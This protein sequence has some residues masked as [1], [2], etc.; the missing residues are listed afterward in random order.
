MVAA[1]TNEKKQM[2]CLK[3]A[4]RKVS[5]HWMGFNL[6][7]RGLIAL[8]IALLCRTM[9]FAVPV[10]D[11]HSKPVIH[12]TVDAIDTAHKILSVRETIPLHGESEITL[13]YPRWEL[14]SH[15]PTVSMANLAGL[16]ITIG[17]HRVDWERDPLDAH[18][19]H[20]KLPHGAQSLD[21]QFQYLSPLN[22][23]TVITRNIVQVQWQHL[24]LYPKGLSVEKLPVEARL[25]LPPSFHAASSLQVD[26]IN[27]S[28][29]S[30]RETS[31]AALVDSPV[32]AGRY[33]QHWS[34]AQDDSVSL[35]LVADAPED[36]AVA[37][38]QIEALSAM[39]SAVE[40][41][42]VSKH[43]RRYKFLASASDVLPNDGGIE[44]LESGEIA[45]PADYFLKPQSY[46]QMATLFAHEFIH[47]WNGLY[48]RPEGMR[49]QDFN[50]PMR[51]SMLWVYE[52]LTEF[53]AM[54]IAKD[55]GQITQNQYLDML[56]LDA[57]MAV[58]RPGRAWKSLAD[59]DNDPVYLAGHHV[60]W[61]DW[62]RRED[63]Y[64]E[65]VLLWLNIDEQIRQCSSGN[66][67]I[68]DFVSSFFTGN[69]EQAAVSMY[70]FPDLIAAL[71]RVASFDWKQFF[72]IRLHAHDDRHVLDGLELA[73][74]RLV[75]NDS[76]SPLYLAQEA[77][78]E[79]IDLS[80]SIGAV[81]DDSGKIESVA[82]Q[83]AAFRAGVAPGMKVL[84][85][86][87]D[88]FSPNALFSA[89][90]A[91]AKDPVHLT[92]ALETGDKEEVELN[93][94]LGLRYPHLRR[95]TS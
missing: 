11:V 4:S 13:L 85:V 58:N 72:A 61:Q 94:S 79:A 46:P 34:L 43:F 19:F 26:R 75:F 93:Y 81:I 38:R 60:D 17:G 29:I 44:H 24:V 78:G 33:T 37:P 67:N 63:Y 31:L 91:S 66:K 2:F 18:E 77:E 95:I 10:A 87:G 40:T 74:Y 50:T 49:T 90:R 76:A 5:Q 42:F 20:V 15:A 21:V 35:D 22:R 8:A 23:G 30:Y 16:V 64:F 88:A 51:D 53:L 57:A 55:S 25:I 14:A 52:G 39:V 65:G 7:V 45:V 54:R 62:E 27:G 32:F 89:I 83:G 3:N 59:S 1:A 41:L 56:A 12:L 9:C 86:N 84:K 80:Y 70:T 36:L 92:L 47:S 28:T 73:G 69:G 48:R 82:W 6:V 71:N 68:A